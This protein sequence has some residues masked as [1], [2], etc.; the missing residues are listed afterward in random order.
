MR[1]LLRTIGGD[2]VEPVDHPGVVAALVNQLLQVVAASATALAAVNVD[3]VDPAD[4]VREGDRAVARHMLALL[5][6]A[7]DLRSSAL[8][9]RFW[10]GLRW[11]HFRLAPRGVELRS[12]SPAPRWGERSALPTAGPWLRA[13]QSQQQRNPNLR[14]PLLAKADI[15]LCR[16]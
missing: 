3:D 1:A 15:P 9:A 14:V 4:Q 16:I 5:R 13:F 8:R 12:R 11:H 2:L 6:S 7:V 10:S